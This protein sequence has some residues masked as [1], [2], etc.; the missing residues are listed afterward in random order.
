MSDAE[1]QTPA[2]AP[3]HTLCLGEAL[4]DLICEHPASG[5]G[6]ATAF[7]PH[8][9]GSVANVA[10]TAA[11]AGA[12]M[13]LAGG[14]GADGWGEWLHER[15]EREGVELSQFRRL[16]DAQTAVAIVTVDQDGEA[17]YAFYGDSIARATAA[18]GDALEPAVANSAALFFSS[19]TLVGAQ[20]RELTMRAR[21]AALDSD[22][23]VIFDPN[24][25]LD[26]WSSRADAQASCNACI[27]GAFLVRAGQAEVALLTGEEDPERA[28]TA[29][30]KAG[31]QLVVVSLGAGGAILRGALRAEVEAVPANVV[32][33]IG[34]GD[35]FTGTLL[36]KLALSD[37]YP[38]VVAAAL[39]QAAAAA[40]AACERWGAI[41]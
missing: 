39:P 22:R 30:L 15:L 11:R 5:L 4:V 16:A 34:A 8:C 23:P 24:L 37:Y 33:T 14:R 35:A 9:G 10:V 2:P 7:V 29:L 36:A 1:T 3:T 19:N 28:A 17:R 40:A 38:P 26:R 13:S 6:E 32:S 21:Q 12:R 25:R 41:D 20:E 18:L 27:P 31:A